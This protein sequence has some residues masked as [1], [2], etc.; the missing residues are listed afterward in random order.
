[1]S[2]KYKLSKLGKGGGRQFGQNPKK[3]QFFLVR[4]PLR[5]TT[6]VRILGI[7][8]GFDSKW[9]GKVRNREGTDEELDEEEWEVATKD[10]WKVEDGHLC[11]TIEIAWDGGAK[12]RPVC[13]IDKGFSLLNIVI[14]C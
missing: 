8:Y 11:Q 5:S 12:K 6:Q 9:S 3:Q 10:V 4:P 13:I 2:D 7:A 1:M 14:N